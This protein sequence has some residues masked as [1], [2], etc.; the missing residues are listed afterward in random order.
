MQERITFRATTSLKIAL[1]SGAKQDRRKL[2]NFVVVLLEEA[3]KARQ[4][5]EQAAA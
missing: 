3:L 5:K 2:S 1:K 4:S